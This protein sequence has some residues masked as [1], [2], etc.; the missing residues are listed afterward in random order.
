VVTE[1]EFDLYLVGTAALLVD[2][3]YAPQDA[4]AALRSWRQLIAERR[5]RRP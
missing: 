4:P 5:G 2:L 1:F 3:F